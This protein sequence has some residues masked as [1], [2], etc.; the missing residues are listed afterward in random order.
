MWYPDEQSTGSVLFF[1]SHNSQTCMLDSPKIRTVSIPR[2]APVPGAT[3]SL[4]DCR[5]F[6][7]T[8][9]RKLM[10][11]LLAQCF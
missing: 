10:L 6:V 7:E 3:R 4:V 8:G 9:I 5:T 2:C 11:G 1:I